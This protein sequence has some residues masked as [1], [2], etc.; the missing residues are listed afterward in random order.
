MRDLASPR[1][2]AEAVSQTFESQEGILFREVIPILLTDQDATRANVEKAM[3]WVVENAQEDDEITFFWSG[4]G[5]TQETQGLLL[6]YLFPHKAPLKPRRAEDL[7]QDMVTINLLSYSLLRL[8][9]RKGILVLDTCHS[10][11]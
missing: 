2:D 9:A 5:G 4:Y 3:N 7:E 6:F 10:K 11:E 8:K 1:S